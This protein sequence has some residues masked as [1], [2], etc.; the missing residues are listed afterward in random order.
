MK[1]KKE[2]EKNGKRITAGEKRTKQ[3]DERMQKN[4]KEESD[5]SSQ[6]EICICILVPCIIR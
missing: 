3:R 5:D 6:W 4:E 1:K 2:K